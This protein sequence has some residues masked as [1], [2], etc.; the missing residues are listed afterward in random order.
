[1]SFYQD[2]SSLVRVMQTHQLP[3][4]E[5]LDPAIYSIGMVDHPKYGV[6]MV[7]RKEQEL[8]NLPEKIVG[9]NGWY[10]EEI[11]ADYK[12]SR[13]RPGAL[14]VLL[15]GMAGTG[16]TTLGEMLGNFFISQGHPVFIVK[17]R[18]TPVALIREAIAAVGECAVIFEEMGKLYSDIKQASDEQG[19]TQSALLTLFSDSGLSN[20]MFIATEN[21]AH[22]ISNHALNRPGRFKYAIEYRGLSSESVKEYLEDQ[23]VNAQLIEEIIA[24]AGFIEVSFDMLKTLTK[25]ALRFPNPT[26]FWKY[27]GI[28]NVPEPLY[29]HFTL[30]D[31]I[32]LGSFKATLDPSL[33]SLHVDNY[34]EFCF[35]IMGG[36]GSTHEKKF[37]AKEL[38]YEGKT[39]KGAYVVTYYDFTGVDGIRLRLSCTG[40]PTPTKHYRLEK[41]TLI[42]YSTP[43]EKQLAKNKKSKIN[44]H[45][46]RRL[47]GASGAYQAFSSE[48]AV[49]DTA[50]A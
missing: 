22:D 7:F 20:V 17:E 35:T 12:L 5:K 39:G 45:E 33:Y 9:E 26:A 47:R 18:Q 4:V 23:G 6:H 1:M 30:E 36:D 44:A 27:V 25:A 15:T 46:N 37:N 31:V 13:D 32:H 28:L 8:F 38:N 2:G 10:F 16:K 42:D 40:K 41:R 48:V 11:I 14:G 34:N 43:E 50:E 3:E 21:N 19:A 29:A 49:E 24:Y